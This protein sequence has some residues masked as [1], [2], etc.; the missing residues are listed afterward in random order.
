MGGEVLVWTPQKVMSQSV[1]CVVPR[2]NAEEIVPRQ[3][4]ITPRPRLH[5]Q[6]PRV[7][8]LTTYGTLL[9]GIQWILAPIRMLFDEVDD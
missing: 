5:R 1:P 8:E 9:E 7:D 6:C 2:M 3:V 4:R